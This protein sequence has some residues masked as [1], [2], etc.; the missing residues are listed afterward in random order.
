MF[1]PQH[2]TQYGHGHRVLPGVWLTRHVCRCIVNCSLCSLYVAVWFR[3][4][5]S[6]ITVKYT[7]TRQPFYHFITTVL[8]TRTEITRWGSVHSALFQV[9]AV[10]GGAFTVAGIFDSLLFTAAEIFKKAELGKL[11]WIERRVDW[12]DSATTRVVF[13]STSIA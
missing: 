11:S 3:Y 5:L 12:N 2:Y 6:P 13:I 8:V 7:V 9:C 4:D 1:W 10:V